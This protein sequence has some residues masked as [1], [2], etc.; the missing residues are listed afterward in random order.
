MNNGENLVKAHEV[1]VGLLDAPWEGDAAFRVVEES[2]S[3]AEEA[4]QVLGLLT[5]ALVGML[6]SGTV[7]TDELV[8]RLR[9]AVAF[10]AIV[11]GVQDGDTS[12]DD[13]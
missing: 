4:L 5:I 11:R 13:R 10:E 8:Q 9:D 7:V 6:R 12:D 1:L 3:S 2:F